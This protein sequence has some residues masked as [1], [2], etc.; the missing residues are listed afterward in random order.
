MPNDTELNELLRGLGDQYA[1]PDNGSGEED[2][3]D[4][5]QHLIDLDNSINPEDRGDF[6]GEES[7]EAEPEEEEV[8]EEE[9][10]EE[11]EETEPATD[12][13]SKKEKASPEIVAMQNQIKGLLEVVSN[14]TETIQNNRAGQSQEATA[15]PP[16]VPDPAPIEFISDVEFENVFTD[17]NSLNALLNKVYAQGQQSTM[18][19]VVPIIN[20]T[21]GTQLNGFQ[22]AQNFFSANPDLKQLSPQIVQ[23]VTLL[24][25]KNPNMTQDQL[26]DTAGKNIRLRYNLQKAKGPNKP[27]G[28]VK[29][30][31]PAATPTNPKSRAGTPKGV[32]KLEQDINELFDYQNQ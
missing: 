4:L 27:V 7:E 15:T 3:E 30:K 5:N 28:K 32:S 21:V 11:V 6:T 20:N 23:E 24:S 12:K 16:G 18:Q 31:A 8:E 1:Q 29:G 13:K 10:D 19:Q 17:K 14:L 26:L 25:S 22:K 9:E 2:S